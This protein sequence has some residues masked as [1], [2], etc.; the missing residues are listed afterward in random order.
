MERSG[1]THSAAETKALGRLLVQEVS[2]RLLVCLRGEM[3]AGKTTFTQGFLE[4]LGASRPY[5]SPT[6]VIMKQYDLIKPSKTGIK[7]VYHAD[8]YRV[9]AKDFDHLGFVEWCGDPI[10]IVLLEWPER[11]ASLLPARRLEIFFKTVSETGRE[12]TLHRL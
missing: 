2:P 7:R 5:V 8:A 6:F 3:G 4:A 11:V 1:I 9:A 10:G 12:I